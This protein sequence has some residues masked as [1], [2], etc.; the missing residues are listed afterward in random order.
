MEDPKQNSR[1]HIMN[2]IPNVIKK[3]LDEVNPTPIRILGD[4]PN[5]VLDSSN[6]LES[7]RPFVS[8]VEQSICEHCPGALTCFVAVNIYPGNHS[9]FALD[10]NN[11]RYNHETAHND[12]T[13]IPVYVL[14]L[15]VRTIQIFRKEQ[16]DATLAETLAKMHNG[17]GY[18]PLPLVE[19]HNKL[20]E[21]YNPR[22]LG[23]DLHP[24]YHP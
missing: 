22:S 5:H 4:T 14:R 10:L 9:F 1:D 24:M 13:P 6:Y 23:L 15:S 19:D 20:V 12:K 2:Q 7:I 18:D 11:F 3:F 21:Y 16:L 8:K 17:H